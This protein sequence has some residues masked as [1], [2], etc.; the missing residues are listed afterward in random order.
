MKL[1]I[2]QGPLQYWALMGGAL[3]V[4]AAS[5]QNKSAPEIT[6]TNFAANGLKQVTISFV[7]AQSD[8]KALN[9]QDVQNDYV[10]LGIFKGDK[11]VSTAKLELKENTI[12]VPF[13]TLTFKA[14][15]VSSRPSTGE[16]F[17]AKAEN[18]E[19]INPNTETL[20]VQFGAYQK[21]EIKK[22]FGLAYESNN[23]PA[24]D[25]A[26]SVIDP[27]SGSYIDLPEDAQLARSDARGVFALNYFL[28]GDTVR[29]RLKKN[30]IV[31]EVLLPVGLSP[32]NQHYPLPFVNLTGTDQTSPFLV[33][34]NLLRGA[35]GTNGSD[36]A[37]GAVGAA[38]A[39]GAA[40]ASVKILTETEPNSTNCP[41][42]GSKISTW[43]QAA[44]TTSSVY[45][46]A[47]GSSNLQTSY[48]CSATVPGLVSLFQSSTE[49]GKLLQA[50]LESYLV[51]DGRY[52]SLVNYGNPGQLFPA[53]EVSGGSFN[54]NNPYIAFDSTDCSGAPL[55]SRNSGIALR[56]ASQYVA[57]SNVSTA[58][59]G[60]LLLA[61]SAKQRNGCFSLGTR[62]IGTAMKLF[63]A[64]GKLFLQTDD[65]GNQGV[66]STTNGSSW[67]GATVGTGLTFNV[68][69]Y[70]SQIYATNTGLIALAPALVTVPTATATAAPT[71]NLG[72]YVTS[73]AAV[74]WQ[75]S[76][77]TK[78]PSNNTFRYTFVSSTGVLVAGTYSET[79]TSDN[80]G[81]SW[82]LITTFGYNSPMAQDGDDIII[83]DT[84]DNTL[85]KFSIATS[86]AQPTVGQALGTPYYYPGWIA[87]AGGKTIVGANQGVLYQP[88]FSS[89]LSPVGNL[90]FGC[91]YQS[92]C[93]IAA[94]NNEFFGVGFYDATPIIY[95]SANAT[96]WAPT[97]VVNSGYLQ[98]Q[99]KYVA[100]N[101]Y[102]LSQGKLWKSVD[103][104]AFTQVQLPWLLKAFVTRQLNFP[105]SV[106]VPLGTLSSFF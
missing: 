37:A 67:V 70:Y 54:A 7:S 71:P 93:F 82:D 87:S 13:D 49:V 81:Q 86:G 21:A 98:F 32:D 14:I 8:E 50:G 101:Y 25:Y 16:V 43:T 46:A 29:L 52:I 19:S 69:D 60:T 35:N 17:L 62:Q 5:C 15:I 47:A 84:T 95:K 65:A 31:K 78:P 36:G 56:N 92:N 42:G 33:D 79:Y 106:S 3:I 1:K 63:A 83:G 44:G 88:N 9:L 39:A 4:I 12:T 38:G 41:N 10:G 30:N 51:A 55:S 45:N 80:N 68:S 76:T 105:T 90:P 102:I 66:Y 26:I 103:G 22:V 97:N 72:S 18:T 6:S 48:V 100:G 85:K 58:N 11:L 34:L 64:G 91:A 59:L 75:T 104:T 40:G 28:G 73:D 61:G 77:L 2:F 23:V 24:S 96:T 57:T 53:E 94:A 20:S 27:F 89:A 74:S 99:I